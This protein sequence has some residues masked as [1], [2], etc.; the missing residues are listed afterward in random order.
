VKLVLVDN[1]ARETVADVLLREHVPAEDAQ[2]LADAYNKEQGPN[3][4]R[5]CVVKPDDYRLSRGMEDLV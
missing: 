4:Y 1:Y 3:P 5:W 2:E